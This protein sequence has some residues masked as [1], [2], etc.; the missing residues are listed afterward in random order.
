MLAIDCKVKITGPR[1]PGREGYSDGYDLGVEAVVV[2]G[3]A[4]GLWQIKADD[5][6]PIWVSP[7]H[8]ECT[9]PEHQASN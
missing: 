5:L 9:D 8:I 2:K 7:D 3:P 6:R 1:N 4:N